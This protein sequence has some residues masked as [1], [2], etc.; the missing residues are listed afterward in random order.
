MKVFET[1]YRN[2]GW[3]RG[4]G[5]GSAVEGLGPYHRYLQ[6]LLLEK[7]PKKIVD[8]G[9]GYFE[10]YAR[11]DWQDADYVGIDLVEHCIKANKRYSAA[12]RVFRLADWCNVDDLPDA[13]LA[14][15]KD[16]LQHWCHAD[17]CKGLARL[18]R[19]R[20]CL[21]TNS[22]VLGTLRVNGDIQNGDVRPLDL[23][24][25]PYS[26]LASACATYEVITNPQFDRK[27]MIVWEP[28]IHPFRAR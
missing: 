27:Q 21:I 1:I 18:S 26:L 12:R 14:I 15:C 22:I 2:G 20:I 19:Y 13:D 11:L 10:P 7:R 25:K 8:L 3:G 16:V 23:L 9:C 28:R 5:P 4:S 17:V 24:L 6:A